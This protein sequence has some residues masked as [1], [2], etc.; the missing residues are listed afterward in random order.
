MKKILLLLV[1]MYTAAAGKAQNCSNFNFET[2][3]FWGWG[4]FT[5]DNQ[6]SSLGPL[7]NLTPGIVTSGLNALISDPSSRH[8]IVDSAAGNDPC[9]NFPAVLPGGNYSVRLGGTTPNYQ[10]E[11]L[12]QRFL[13]TALDSFISV[14]YAVVLNDGGHAQNEQPYFRI[15]ILDTANNII[16]GGSLYLTVGDSGFLLCSPNVYYLPWTTTSFI[17]APQLGQLV[18]LRITVAGCTQGGHY[19]YAYVDANCYSATTGMAE[20]MYRKLQVAPNPTAGDFTITLPETAAG[21]QLQVTVNDMHGKLVYSS[22]I[23]SG[24]THRLAVD[25]DGWAD[26]IYSVSIR[27]NAGVYHEKIVKQQQ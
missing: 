9:G 1:L 25:A 13:V 20:A 5:G 24:H 14:Y 23:T 10:G 27:G 26:G 12:E 2:G 19:G 17:L 3:N 4:G 21:E 16:P 8:T 11:V 15:D 7:D 18:T 22:M 6:T